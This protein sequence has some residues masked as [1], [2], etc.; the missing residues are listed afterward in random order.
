MVFCVRLSEIVLQTTFWAKHKNQHPNLNPGVKVRWEI[1]KLQV[2]LISDGT[3][4]LKLEMTSCSDN[5]YE[6]TIFC[7]DKFLA[8]TL[9]L[10]SFI[11]VR[12]QMVEFDWGIFCPPPLG[13]YR[14]ILDPVQN[15]VKVIQFSA[16]MSSQSSASKTTTQIK[17]DI[18]LK[19]NRSISIL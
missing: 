3:S 2:N 15:R 9:F 5:A 4:R 1:K 16:Q 17:L 14:G 18:N 8:C 13:H 10:P 7:F 12:R 11:V 6:V 19:T